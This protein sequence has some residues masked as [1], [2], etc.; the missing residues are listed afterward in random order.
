MTVVRRPIVLQVIEL[1][2][3]EV[4]QMEVSI[5]RPQRQM[6][7]S[8]VPFFAKDPPNEQTR[9][10]VGPNAPCK[11]LKSMLASQNGSFPFISPDRPDRSE[12][13]KR[14]LIFETTTK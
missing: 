4:Q 3:I 10:L 9:W 12:N 14:D 1:Q 2:L 7:R 8:T 5:F 6:N 13:V 11:N